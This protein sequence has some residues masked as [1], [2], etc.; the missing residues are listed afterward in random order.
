VIQRATGLN[1]RTIAR[2]RTWAS[3]QGLLDNP[4]PPLED[5]QQLIATT[6]EL[7]PPPP[8]LSSVAPYR[9]LVVPLHRAGVAGTAIWHRMRDRGDQ[10]ALASV[11][12]FLHRLAPAYQTAIVRVEREPGSEAQ[13]DFGY[14][15]RMLDPTTGAL[16][17]TWA[18][19]ML[20]AYSRG[21]STS[22]LSATKPCQPGSSGM[23][24][25]WPSS[26]GC[27][28]GGCST[29]SKRGS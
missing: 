14:A 9:E 20:R 21:S 24:M 13:V 25:P 16:R 5:L 6:L 15:G 4:L 27:P 23:C 3:A 19:V 22:S 7:P 17:K 1:R 10:G 26:A 8:I 12:R 29:T 11:Y 18:F 2:Y 28:T